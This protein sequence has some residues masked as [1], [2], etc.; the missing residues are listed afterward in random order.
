[1]ILR[2]DSGGKY[3][4]I[5]RAPVSEWSGSAS[6]FLQVMRCLGRGLQAS[7]LLGGRY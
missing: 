3:T 5:A 7:A 4:Y 1:M 6:T 2:S